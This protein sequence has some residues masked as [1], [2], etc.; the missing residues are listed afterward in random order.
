M[1]YLPDAG[2]GCEARDQSGMDQTFIMDRSEIIDGCDGHIQLG[3]SEE[4]KQITESEMSSADF[5]VQSEI[6]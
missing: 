4:R 6:A 3:Q 1:L 2:S 5:R